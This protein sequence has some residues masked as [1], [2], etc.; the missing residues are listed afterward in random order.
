[1]DHVHGVS[2]CH[3]ELLLVLNLGTSVIKKIRL[4][5]Y[6]TF[7]DSFDNLQSVELC[8]RLPWSHVEFVLCHLT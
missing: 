7:K 1:M 2:Y 8:Y 5:S 6:E 3:M 4:H